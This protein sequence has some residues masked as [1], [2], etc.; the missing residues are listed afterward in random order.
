MAAKALIPVEPSPSID[1]LRTTSSVPRTPS[2]VFDDQNLELVA[3]GLVDERVRKDAHR[4]SSTTATSRKSYFRGLRE[5]R[6]Q[7]LEFVNKSCGE[8]G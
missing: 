1:S 6:R 7:T 8:Y 5:E 2:I 3:E 4:E